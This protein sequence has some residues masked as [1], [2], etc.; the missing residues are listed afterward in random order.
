MK[1]EG[2][3]IGS[4]VIAFVLGFALGVYSLPI[5]TADAG[6]SETELRPITGR[7]LYT[8]RFERGLTG[9]DPLHWTDGKLSVTRTALAFEGRVAPGPDYK[10]YLTREFV[11]SKQA[12]V[13]AKSRA[14]RVGELK[15]FG[16]FV[17][18]LA[19]GV[20]VGDYTTVVIWC[21]RFSQFIGAAKYR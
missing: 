4:H 13:A 6:A 5:L 1:K 10:I 12:F 17:V 9:G 3:W 11:A 8:G 19:D 16:D 21:E 18:P 20:D 2:I 15:T 7:A 14:L